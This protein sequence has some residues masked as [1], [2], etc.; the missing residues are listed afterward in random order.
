MTPLVSVVIVGYR[1]RGP[2]ERCLASL[3]RCRASIDLEC[4]LVDNAPEDGTGAWVACAHPWVRH[5]ENPE[6][7]GFTRG[8]NQGAA[9]ATGRLLLVL[10]P[11][12]EV[13]TPALAALARAASAPGIGAVAPALIDDAG[14]RVHSCGRFPGLWSL[15][16]D[17]LGL[18]GLFRESTLF[19][20]YKYG[21]V[22]P[23]DLN[24]VDWAS[25][26][27]LMIPA[28]VWAQ[29]G[30]LDERIF[31][32]MEEVDWCLRARAA[33]LAVRYM[34]GTRI[35]H[36]GQ[37]SSRQAPTASYLHNLRSRVYYFR[38]HHGAAAVACAKTIL[39]LSLALKWLA[40]RPRP[41]TLENARIYAA[42][43][44]AV[45]AA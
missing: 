43:I 42:G 6:N 1:S 8:V 13:E 15:V 14:R 28:S 21:G 38:K 34:P 33:G 16:C 22:P 30:G 26:A 19:G 7:V 12:C 24:R 5:I 11:D 45:W 27:A 39:A 36:V 18:A 32:Y 2:L 29:V 4:V 23:E 35:I 44:E 37:C 3:A 10:N 17:H 31:M 9:A 20:R 41:A 40:T 25:G